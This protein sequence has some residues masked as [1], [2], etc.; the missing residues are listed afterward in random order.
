LFA[1]SAYP[2]I[3][4]PS[5]FTAPLV[6]PDPDTIC[7][8][9]AENS[10]VGFPPTPLDTYVGAST[11]VVPDPHDGVDPVPPETTF[12][13]AEV[14]MHSHPGVTAADADATPHN[15]INPAATATAA[16]LRT[17]SPITN[18]FRPLTV[19]GI[20]DLPI[21]LICVNITHTSIWFVCCL[22]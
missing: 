9:T 1:F 19:N 22:S 16:R 21:S 6:V 20:W 5:P 11:A 14:G 13:P 18:S 10:T 12:D 8:F 15:D 17:P 3:R 2:T 4:F 7:T